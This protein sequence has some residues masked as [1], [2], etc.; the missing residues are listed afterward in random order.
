MGNLVWQY[1]YS[2]KKIIKKEL[3][4]LPSTLVNLQLLA[5]LDTF[6]EIPDSFRYKLRFTLDEIDYISPSA[7]LAGKRIT[8]SYKPATSADAQ[9]MS[10]AE[11]IL[12]LPLY[13]VNVFPEL[14]VEGQ[15]VA[16]GAP[17][18][19]GKD[20]IMEIDF[21]APAKPVDKIVNTV[22][23]GEYYA[24]GLSLQKNP[25]KSVYDRVNNWGPET[26]EERDDRLGE[27]LHLVSMLYHSKLEMF[28]SK[29]AQTSDIIYLRFPAECMVGLS[30]EATSVLGVPTSVA[31]VGMNIDV[32]RDI[33]SPFS[34]VGNEDSPQAI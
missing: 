30:F 31:S 33:I 10:E 34:K 17:V 18:Q 26:A 9:V 20:Q 16:T 15:V 25:V 14:R 8:I 22:K 13:L 21:Y 29:L 23:A 4:F 19:M 11:G 7:W 6:A 5:K 3:R 12:D 2:Y 24:I 32:D 27:L 28:M 1:F